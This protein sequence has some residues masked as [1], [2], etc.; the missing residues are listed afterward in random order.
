LKTF[1]NLSTTLVDNKNNLNSSNSSNLFSGLNSA[2]N[3]HKNEILDLQSF[4]KKSRH[5]FLKSKSFSV[6]KKII[7]SRTLESLNLFFSEILSSTFSRFLINLEKN[8]TKKISVGIKFLDNFN[9]IN[10]QFLARFIARRVSYGFQLQ[11]VLKPLIRDLVTL[12]S[13][14]KNKIIGFRIACSGRFDRKQIASYI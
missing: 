5:D 8:K 2:L 1:S 7:L 6:Y 4:S 9:I 11:R 10:P 3:K 13:K 14:K 12:M